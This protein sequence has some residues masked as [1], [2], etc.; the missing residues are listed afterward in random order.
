[1]TIEAIL[2]EQRELAKCWKEVNQKKVGEFM[3]QNSTD[4]I[5]WKRNPPLASHMGGVWERQIRSARNILSS[6]MK[7]HRV[8]LDEESLNTLFVEVEGIVNS[9]PLV[10][11][12]INDVNSQA[13]L[14]PS[15]ILTMKSKVVMPPPGVFGTPDLYCRKR[16][17]RVQ[18]ISNEFWSRWRK[19]FLAT[20]QDRQKWKTPL[21][22]FRVRDIVI[23]KEDTQRNDWR[24]AKVIKAYKDDK[25]YVRTVQLYLGCSVVT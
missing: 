1:M 2:W 8:S 9:R 10:V 3:L 5:Q 12:T 13:A 6:L 25:G 20:L 15:H 7:T 11:E 22:N 18:H 24:L 21:K 19:E 23:L 14:S 16:W 4:W 17:R